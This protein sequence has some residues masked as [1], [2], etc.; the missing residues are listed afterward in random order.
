MDRSY[1]YYS[2]QS[3]F[4]TPCSQGDVK[5]HT[6]L[7]LLLF[8]GN[9]VPVSPA[10]NA[11]FDSSL[12]QEAIRNKDRYKLGLD[13]R[14]LERE[15]VVTCGTVRIRKYF[16]LPSLSALFEGL[17]LSKL[18]LRAVFITVNVDKG[19]LYHFFLT[20]RPLTPHWWRRVS[21]FLETFL[22]LFSL[23]KKKKWN[24]DVK[25]L[26]PTMSGNREAQTFL[27]KKYYR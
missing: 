25:I 7:S 23:S 11:I 6:Y 17:F 19:L 26:V 22:S 15:T 8:Q 4:P 21:S 14:V 20:F 2:I 24:T 12:A 3:G 5:W 16:A 18:P 13:Y 1:T 27:L 9:K 10:L